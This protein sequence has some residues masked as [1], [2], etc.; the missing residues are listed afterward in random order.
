MTAITRRENNFDKDK[1]IIFGVGSNGDIL[2]K[3]SLAGEMLV[4]VI[5][6]KG[7]GIY[8]NDWKVL[9]KCSLGNNHQTKKLF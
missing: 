2:D 5:Y 3:F 8:H 7:G 4:R 9:A 1:E 6:K